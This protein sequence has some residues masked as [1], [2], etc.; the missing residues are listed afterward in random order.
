MGS[1]DLLSRGGKLVCFAGLA[2]C[3]VAT[4]EAPGRFP[5]LDATAQDRRYSAM[6][7]A[8][9]K[10]VSGE[11]VF[12]TETDHIRGSVIPLETLHTSL[13]GWCREYEERIA[14]AAG[15]HLLVGIACR[16]DNGQWLI[17]DIHSYVE[18]PRPTEASLRP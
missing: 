8:F 18:A 3:S 1:R 11:T 10:N 2:A 4:T 16:A 5:A 15:G 14:T 9:E 13:Y 17:V 7:Q 6:V 12:W